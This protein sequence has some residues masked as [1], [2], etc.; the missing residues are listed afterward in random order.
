[1][2]IENIPQPKRSTMLTTRQFM[3]MKGDN[4]SHRFSV[5]VGLRASKLHREI[6]GKPPRFR[7]VKTDWRNKTAVF[8]HGILEQAFAQVQDEI[9]ALAEK[10]GPEAWTLL[11]PREPRAER[12]PSL[13]Q[14]AERA[15]RTS[16]AVKE[17]QAEFPGMTLAEAALIHRARSGGSSL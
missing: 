12:A 13:A 9:V 3:K 16:R 1:V 4:W 14:N 7:R 5:L 15:S 6:L 17:I 8:H 10:D 2:D 11:A